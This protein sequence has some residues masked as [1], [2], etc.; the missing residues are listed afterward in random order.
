MSQMGPSL[1]LEVRGKGDT[2]HQHL[3]SLLTAATWEGHR[4]TSHLASGTLGQW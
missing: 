1:G 2:K 4:H 3:A